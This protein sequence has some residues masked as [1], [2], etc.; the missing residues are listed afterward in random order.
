MLQE[1]PWSP[2]TIV[3][4]CKK[5][6]SWKDKPIVCTKT[7]YNYI[8]RGLLKVR[9]IDLL[10]KPGLKPR[11]KANERA[12]KRFMGKSTDLRPKEVETREEFEHWEI[13]TVVGKRSNEAVLL[14]L[15]ERKTRYG[16][17]ISFR[18]KE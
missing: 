9:N 11:S 6:A 7:L 16:I 2:D 12:S 10:L 8:D 3:G 4:Y 18:I 1:K 14:T 13:D 17:Y 5:N 15:T